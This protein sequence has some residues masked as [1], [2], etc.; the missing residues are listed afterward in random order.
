MKVSDPYIKL[1]EWSE[2]DQC[3]IGSSPGFIGSCCHGKDEAKVYKQL[4]GIVEEW[5]DIHQQEGLP[6]PESFAG[7]SFSGKFVIRVGTELHKALA[8][9]A[10]K[11]GASLNHLCTDLLR[12]SIVRRS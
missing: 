4:C 9:K 3:Y 10:A 6:L 2:E 11:S 5:V 7:K 12:S 8:I 1:V